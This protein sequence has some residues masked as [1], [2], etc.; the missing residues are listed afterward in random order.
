MVSVLNVRGN[1]KNELETDLNFV[2]VGRAVQWTKW[3]RPF[4]GNPFTV[5]QHGHEAA[6]RF[7][8]EWLHGTAEGRRRLARLHELNGKVLG[9]WCVDWSG[10]GEPK[11][12]CHAVV[13]ARLVNPIEGD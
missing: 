5:R 10:A 11:R 12:P 13:L 9:C 6:V 7:S 4:W 2:Y 8:E 3:E 1:N